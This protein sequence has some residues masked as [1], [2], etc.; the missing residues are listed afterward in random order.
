MSAAASVAFVAAVNDEAVLRQC[1]AAS[2]DIA[3]GASLSVCRKAAS[4][5][6]AYAD[7]LARADADI[8]VFAHQDVYFPAGWVAHLLAQVAAVA[9]RDADWAVMGL[10]GLGTDGAVLG[11]AW[12][13][14][15]GAVVGSERMLPARAV[16]LDEMVLIVRRDSGVSFDAAMPGF[17]L[18][19][20]DLVENAAAA[21]RGVWVIDCPAVHHSKP[22]IRLDSGYAAAWH[23]MRRK[24][25]DRLPIRNLV[26]DIEA[27]PWAL[28]RK[29]IRVRWKHRGIKERPAPAADPAAIARQLGWEP[30][31]RDD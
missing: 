20:A 7:A 9:A 12:S 18:Y 3:G 11:R 15:L 10:A 25:A 8:V 22:V 1:L 23:F 21:G 29:Q 14:G 6:A 13:S 28:W 4:A 26:C 24:Y 31:A 16:T 5:S 17:H 2:P 19:A 27:Q 30:A